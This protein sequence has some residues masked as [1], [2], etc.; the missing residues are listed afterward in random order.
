MSMA[1][2][3]YPDLYIHPIRYCV[4]YNDNGPI[5]YVY[6]EEQAKSIVQGLNL[7]HGLDPEVEIEENG[8]YRFAY[9]DMRQ[10]PLN[11]H[12]PPT[13]IASLAAGFF[14]SVKP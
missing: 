6:T 3:K 9:E 12:L 7:L 10:Y 2:R 4:F 8:Y 14:E 1:N 5:A 13:I 11:G